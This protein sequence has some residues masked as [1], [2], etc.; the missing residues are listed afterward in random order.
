[1]QGPGRRRWN[2]GQ[3]DY[4][5]E[6]DARLDLE[7]PHDL[8]V[9]VEFITDRPATLTDRNDP[10]VRAVHGAVEQVSGRG[11]GLRRGAGSHG[12]HLICGP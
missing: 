11:A 5:Q 4:Y 10:L 2:A 3:R 6:Y 9:G 7:R 8:T 12:R 1:M